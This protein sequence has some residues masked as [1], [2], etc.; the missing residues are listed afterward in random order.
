MF[1]LTP[2]RKTCNKIF[3]AFGNK[4]KLR[5]C[6]E[7]II[8]K[9]KKHFR[10]SGAKLSLITVS[11]KMFS[12]TRKSHQAVQHQVGGVKMSRTRYLTTYTNPAYIVP[13]SIL[14]CMFVFVIFFSLLFIYFSVVFFLFF[15][16]VSQS[17]TC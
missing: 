7:K 16:L 6:K 3:S 12:G 15:V 14:C 2:I 17:F 13:H 9:Y 4:Q 5:N 10:A 8:N 1:Y 11:V